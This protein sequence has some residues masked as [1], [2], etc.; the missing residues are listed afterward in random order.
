MAEPTDGKGLDTIA[1]CTSPGGVRVKT[2]PMAEG[3]AGPQLSPGPG[4]SPHRAP[5]RHNPQSQ[6]ASVTLPGNRDLVC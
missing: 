3:A 1:E 4:G 2:E 5:T 6:R